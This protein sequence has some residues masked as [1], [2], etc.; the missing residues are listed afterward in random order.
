[1]PSRLKMLR[2]VRTIFGLLILAATLIRLDAQSGA[3]PQDPIALTNANVLNVLDGTVQRN[4]TVTL[5][6]GRIESIAATPPSTGTRPIDVRGRYVVPGLIDAHV[7]IAN[8]RAL[9]TALQSGVTTVRSSGVSHYADI[10]MRELV[11]QGHVIGA[12]VMA[13]GYHVRPSIAEEAFF[14]HPAQASLMRGV[15]TVDGLRRIVQAN[16]SRGVDWIKVLATERAGTPNTDPRKQVYSEEELRAVVEEAKTKN[17][18][19]QAHAHGAE[20]AL[21]AVKAGV[22]S[23][24]HG[25]YLT[26]EALQLMVKQGTFFDPT[27]EAV[28]DVALPGGDYDNRD[29][30]LRGQ[31]MLPRLRET[32]GRAHKLG[33]KIVAGSDTGYGPESV[34]RLAIEVANLIDSGLPP[35]AALQAATI[36][37]ADMLGKQKQIGQIASGFEADLIVVERNPLEHV[38]TLQDPLL[39]ISNGRIGLDRLNFARTESTP[40]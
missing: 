14:D 10:G 40:Q 32:I 3:L 35:L 37:N 11:K 23:I 13:S 17:V 21:A 24:E 26:D 25:T 12:D 28:K 18:P 34:A 16:L 31:H 30:Q 4:V 19:V 29:L 1:M 5:R 22:R 2:M 38:N 7:H 36:V 33:V 20:G 8:L 39:V 6:G 27:M 9:R 15:T